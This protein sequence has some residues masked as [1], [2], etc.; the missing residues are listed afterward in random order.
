MSYTV[1]II[2][3]QQKE[4]LAESFAGQ[5][6]YEIKSEIYGCCIKLLTGIS[7]VKDRWEDSFYSASQSLRS[8][9]RLYVLQ[10][11]S[12]AQN[13]VCYDPQSKTC[14]LF[15]VDYYGWIKSLAL[16]VAG[17]ILEDEHAIYSVH[18]RVWMP[19]E[20]ACAFWAARERARPHTPTGSCAARACA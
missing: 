20:G 7:S 10:D 15:N 16:S 19:E 12:R 6:L 4:E 11:A 13:Q 3:I 1:E 8:H 18:G 9:G 5:I 2:S 17:D 14:F